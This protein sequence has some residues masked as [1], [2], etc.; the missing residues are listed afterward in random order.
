MGSVVRLQP[1]L[2]LVPMALTFFPTILNT[3]IT[4]W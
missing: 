3:A 2:T 1:T 4:H